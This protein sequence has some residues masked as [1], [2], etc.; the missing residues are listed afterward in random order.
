MSDDWG[1][2][3]GVA[4]TLAAVI[5]NNAY[6]RRAAKRG[7]VAA[8]SDPAG[9]LAAAASAPAAGTGKALTKAA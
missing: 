1:R 8:A 6:G 5:A 7:R 3:L 4:L 9:G 2:G